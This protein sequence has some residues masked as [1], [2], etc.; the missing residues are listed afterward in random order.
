MNISQKRAVVSER[1]YR[2]LEML[3]EQWLNYAQIAE[4]LGI[5][6][7]GAKNAL[8]RVLRKVG[9]TRREEL[10]PIWNNPETRP[11]IGTWRQLRRRSEYM[12]LLPEERAALWAQIRRDAEE[13]AARTGRKNRLASYLGCHYQEILTLS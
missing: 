4:Q 6:Y 8:C 3:V 9:V 11:F 2:V 12:N 5:S 7:Q 1:E 13:A 10:V